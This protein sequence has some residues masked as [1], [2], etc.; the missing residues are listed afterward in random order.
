M[1]S[2][3]NEDWKSYLEKL[4]NPSDLNEAE[5]YP[6]DELT[7]ITNMLFKL[8]ADS[9]I[10]NI[11]QS[12]IVEEFYEMLSDKGFVVKEQEQLLFAQP[13]HFSP[14][15]NGKLAAALVNMFVASRPNY[16]KFMSALNRGG[17][18]AQSLQNAHDAIEPM[19]RRVAA[20]VRGDTQGGQVRQP[21]EEPTTVDAE[22]E[23]TQRRDKFQNL[24][25]RLRKEPEGNL[26]LDFGERAGI[27]KSIRDDFGNLSERTRTPKEMPKT[28]KRIFS[29]PE[30]KQA[31]ASKIILDWLRSTKFSLGPNSAVALGLREPSGGD[32]DND[33][34][35]AVLD[36]LGLA[37]LVSPQGVIISSGAG[38]V[39]LARS[40]LKKDYDQALRDLLMVI[41]YGR[42]L[43]TAGKT[44]TQAEKVAELIKSSKNSATI[45]NAV[46]GANDLVDGGLMNLLDEAIES[47]P[48][49][50]PGARAFK[51]FWNNKKTEAEAAPDPEANKEPIIPSFYS[52]DVIKESTIYRWQKLAGIKKRV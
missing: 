15:A 45:M 50:I 43:K 24:N 47:I 14:P 25:D 16:E 40:L 38:F 18:S 42:L 27:I 46:K 3:L 13:L 6:A 35:Q 5:E 10:K 17:F 49:I 44:A 28:I 7:V 39:S 20:N 33:K 52:E 48:N 19:A 32:I 36:I 23:V 41:P 34:T 9:G 21:T 1:N 11:D 12:A 8:L 29:L 22:E 51:K 4:K 26:A 30:D 2:E 37:S 31:V